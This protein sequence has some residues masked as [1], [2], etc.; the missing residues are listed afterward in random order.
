MTLNHCARWNLKIK[1]SL[2]LGST[3]GL[4]RNPLSVLIHVFARKVLGITRKPS[5]QGTFIAT[6]QGPQGSETYTRNTLSNHVQTKRN[7]TILNHQD[8]HAT[9]RDPTNQRWTR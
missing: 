4:T 9:A 7:D 1:N 8:A 6:Q 2:F 5:R 3:P